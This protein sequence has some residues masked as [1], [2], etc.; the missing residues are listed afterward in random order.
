MSE[1]KH[2]AIHQE[3]DI[4]A[5]RQAGRALAAQLG[6]S[7]TEQTLIATA[8]SEIARNI[9]VYAERGEIALRRLDELGR[10]G[11]EVTATD[12]G[13]GIADIALAMRDGYSTRN[14]LGLG[15]PGA[16]RLMDEM[17]VVSEPGEGTRVTMKKWRR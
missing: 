7:A 6:F 16:K 13:P 17:A 2:V 12:R 5:A 3:L 11:I 4:V 9:V 14:S 8:I 1:E 15:L 10:I